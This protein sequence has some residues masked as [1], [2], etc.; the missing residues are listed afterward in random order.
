MASLKSVVSH[1]DTYL[2]IHAIQDGS[3]NGLQFEGSTLVQKILFAVDAGAATFEKAV[4]AN[5][6][7]VVVHHGLF[8]KDTNPSYKDLMKKRCAILYEN[9]ISLYA[10]HLPLDS[11][12]KV[13]NNAGIIT[14]IGARVHDD[15]VLV[16]GKPISYTGI[17]TTPITLASITKKLNTTLHT[18]CTILPFGPKRI[19]RVGVVSGGCSHAHVEESINRKLDLFITGEQIEVYHMAKDAGINVIFAGHHATETIGVKA[20]AEYIQKKLKIPTLFVD[21]PTGL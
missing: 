20:L 10:A 17:F 16:N 14:L 19:K 12:I 18:V 3:W 5:A 8:W 1:L 21:I 9:N 2:D 6:S 7:M 11:H 4:E 15:F 13:G